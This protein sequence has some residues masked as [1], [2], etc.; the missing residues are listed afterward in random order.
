MIR[1]NLN[2]IVLGA[3][4]T[5]TSLFAG[6]AEYEFQ[7]NS[8]GGVEAGY[9]I[10]D[11]ENMTSTNN[12]Q[13]NVKS[14]H[15]GLK[16]GAETEDFRVFV[17]G[18]YYFDSSSD[19]DYITTYGV[20][21]QYKFNISQDM[22]FYLGASTGVANMKFQGKGE[23]FSR[24]ISDSYVGG[25]LGANVHLT[26]VLDWEIG[27]RVISIQAENNI[28]SVTYN[29]GNLVSGYTSLIFKWQMD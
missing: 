8:L 12:E 5:S 26:P 14:M 17:S 7:T 3:F 22:N 18:R 11:Y 6:I 25:D 13:Y 2:K 21:L 15:G 4:L 10:L 28:N 1:N 9:S 16:I 24:T 19:Y 23:T 20:E 27:A 29:I